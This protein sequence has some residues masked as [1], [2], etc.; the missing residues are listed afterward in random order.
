MTD[1]KFLKCL[2]LVFSMNLHYKSDAYIL[3]SLKTPMVFDL[4][5]D[6]KVSIT[7]YTPDFHDIRLPILL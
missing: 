3:R 1:P 6:Y 2:L 5:T 4:K 7:D